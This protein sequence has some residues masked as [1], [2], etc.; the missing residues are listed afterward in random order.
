MHI[1][2]KFTSKQ[3]IELAV[4]NYSPDQSQPSAGE[5]QAEE[6]FGVTK[7]RCWIKLFFLTKAETSG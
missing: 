5:Q 2:T 1:W 6:D 7:G 4:V 3:I